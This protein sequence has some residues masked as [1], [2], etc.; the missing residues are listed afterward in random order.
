MLISN[1]STKIRMLFYLAAFAFFS[2]G[3][4]NASGTQRITLVDKGKPSAVIVI[5]KDA[6]R[7]AQFAASELQYHIRKITGADIP[8]VTEDTEVIGTRVLVG[9]SKYTRELGIRNSDFKPMEYL[10]SFR[11]DALILVGRD[12]EDRGVLD[13]N[14]PDTFPADFDEQ[15]TCYAVYDFLE[16]YCGVRWHLPT[17]FGLTCKPQKT[18]KI[19]GKDIRR[20]S[21]VVFRS[22]TPLSSPAKLWG[23]TVDPPANPELVSKRDD[24]LWWRRYRMGGYVFSANHSLYGYYDRFLKQHPD[25]FAQGYDGI[26]PQM[27][28]TN[29]EFI[30]QV[31]QDARDYFDG[32]GALPGSRAEGDYFPLVPMDGAGWCKCANCQ[33][34]LKKCKDGSVSDYIFGFINKVARE[35]KKTHPNKH[36]SALAYADYVLPPSTL[37]LDPHV[38]L[39][40]CMDFRVNVVNTK[41]DQLMMDTFRSWVEESPDRERYLWLY[42]CWPAAGAWAEQYRCFPGFFAHSIVRYMNAYNKA[43][44]RGITLQPSFINNAHRSPLLDQLEWYLVW[45][46]ADD[47]SLDG[48]KLIDRFF[49]EY[50]GSAAKPM[51]RLYEQIED[52]YCNS[53]NYPA[54]FNTLPVSWQTEE[55]AWKYLGTAERMSEMGKLMAQAK[56]TAITEQEKQRVALF[57]EGIWQY[58]VK[59]RQLYLERLAQKETTVQKCRVT[60]SSVRAAGDP[61]KVNWSEAGVLS[62]WLTLNG[63]PIDRKIEGRM[64]HDGEYLYIRLQE[65]MDTS[66][67]VFTDN[68]VYREDDWEIWF[69]KERELP[70]RHMGVNMK[71]FH[72]DLAFGESGHKWDSGAVV[73]SDIKAS[74]WTV[75]IAIPLSQLIPGG[76]KPGD[77]FYTNIIRGAPYVEVN[78]A[79]CWI[80][81]FGK[82]HEPSRFGE[83]V[84]SE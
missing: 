42:F 60:K 53:K 27:C 1:M 45:R 57:E 68:N 24:A 77:K 34:E 79:I 4:A 19:K 52:I 55:I 31:V 48:N 11:S 37:K 69:A 16:R 54:E 39:M 6:V 35:V 36:I 8:I 23:D 25:W 74:S 7:S 18:L 28:Y 43:G 30:K 80:P 17:E 65:L 22:T 21:A 84:L 5:A 33:A 9:E 15:G 59:G 73:V 70:F 41:A 38:S 12:K 13:Y 32:K 71:G 20:T 26:P 46:M 82:F 2:I 83:I 29:P 76:V 47:P 56:K 66:K 61:A 14:N 10:I 49:K 44:I 81:T 3:A 50:Y 67:L 72:L 63:K 51:Q 40:I 62:N 64:I 75:D 78:K 58:M